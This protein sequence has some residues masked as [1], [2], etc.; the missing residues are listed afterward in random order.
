MPEQCNKE[1]ILLN[2]NANNISNKK[3]ELKY[4]L[5]DKGIQ[6]ACITETHLSADKTFNISGFNVIRKDREDQKGGG[7]LILVEK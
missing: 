4:F 3:N 6:I 5:K 1:L 7:V 2:W